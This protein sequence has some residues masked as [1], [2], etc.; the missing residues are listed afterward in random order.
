[1]TSSW[2]DYLLFKMK[3]GIWRERQLQVVRGWRA[4]AA[5]Q[6][7]TL[8]YTRRLT[9]FDFCLAVPA[10]WQ[11]KNLTIHVVL[12]LQRYVGCEVKR[13]LASLGIHPA[14]RINRLRVILHQS[15]VWN[16]SQLLLVLYDMEA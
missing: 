2:L 11:N 8:M 12:R 14:I 10:D 6:R 4:P 9:D 3:E 13:R 1:M 16:Q 5:S 15:M 7:L